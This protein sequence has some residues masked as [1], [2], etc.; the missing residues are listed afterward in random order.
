MGRT[1]FVTAVVLSASSVFAADEPPGLR[2]R[3]L[4][5]VKTQLE[6]LPDFVCTQSVDRYSRVSADQAWSALDTV[7]FETALVGDRELYA[8]PGSAHFDAKP[9]VAVAGRGTI[10]GGQFA[11][12]A[13]H[14]FLSSAANFTYVGQTEQAGRAAYQYSYDVPADQSSYHLRAGKDDGVTAFQGVFWVD[15]QNLDLIR[16]EVQAY[17][18]PDSLGLTEAET[19]LD[20]SRVEI[21]GAEALLPAAATLTVVATDGSANMNRTRFTAWRHYR[22]ES[23]IQFAS[24]AKSDGGESDRIVPPTPAAAPLVAKGAV[25]ELTLDAGLDPATA[26]LGD[27]LVAKIV[28]L[29]GGRSPVSEGTPVRVR[30]IRLDKVDMP[31]PIFEVGLQVESLAIADRQVPLVAT[32]QQAGPAPGLIRQSKHLHPTFTRKRSDHI[33]I[34]VP[35]I[36]RGQGILEWDARKGPIPRGLHMKWRVD[37]DADSSDLASTP[38]QHR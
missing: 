4:A 19:D 35:E 3:L 9:L 17:D 6:H 13:R 36:A 16:L 1:V 34:L 33:D 7:R 31:F 10:G 23:T 24:D 12:M 11:M 15:K 22:A 5:H 25:I 32:M 2:E 30:L 8:L 20:Y 38:A 18:I 21:D 37:A 29:D 27:S 28:R 26:K 14:V